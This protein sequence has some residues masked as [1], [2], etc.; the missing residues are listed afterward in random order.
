MV[1][2]VFNLFDRSKK[3][4]YLRQCQQ[5][6]RRL[7]VRHMLRDGVGNCSLRAQTRWLLLLLIVSLSTMLLFLW[8]SARHYILTGLKVQLAGEL[9]M[10]S[11]RIGKAMPNAIQGSPAAFDQLTQSRQ[12]FSQGIDI[13]MHGG[14][15]QGYLLQAPE[16]GSQVLLGEVAKVWSRTDQVE[17]A[18][19][20][21]QPELTGFGV[22]L[23]RLCQL[24]R[25][26]QDL[27][28]QILA[29]QSRRGFVWQKMAAVK[30]VRLTLHLGHCT[31]ALP[32]M[33]SIDPEVAPVLG[34]DV[35]DLREAIA[36]YLDSHRG[37]SVRGRRVKY[38]Q[39]IHEKLGELE[40]IF[41]DYEPLA[42]GILGNFQNFV[43]VKQA[44]QL[45]IA[46]NEL[47]LQQLGVLQH[48]Y[49]VIQA[50]R[51]WSFWLA[52]VSMAV[53]LLSAFG[54][55]W[56]QMDA[57]RRRAAEAEAR[58]QDA[59]AQRL[60]AQQ[61]ELR[62]IR[63]NAD[64]QEAILRLMEELQKVAD[65][66]LTVHTP[67]TD[68]IAGA[69]A[70]SVNY[71][72]AALRG[73]VSQ[74][75]HIAAQV[76]AASSQV[77]Q[78][79]EE[80]IQA[81]QVQA[82]R[83]HDTGQSMLKMSLHSTDVSISANKSADVARHSVVVAE[84]GARA[85]EDA[86]KGMNEIREQIQETSKRIKRLGVSSQEIGE[87]TE[88]ISD[89]T[90]QTNVLAL[91]A[92]IQAASAGEAGRGFSVVAEEVQRLA[93]RSSAAT[94]QIGALVRMIQDDT[95][96]A[97]AAMEKSTAGVVEGARLSDAAGVSLADIRRVSNQLAELIQ[98]ISSSAGHQATLANS[99][100]QDI[101]NIL[102][103]SEIIEARREQA[104]TLFTEL[105]ELA[106][107]LKNSASC[108]RVTLGDTPSA[109]AS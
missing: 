14:I 97:A 89:I 23:V 56:L 72:V 85:V 5:F 24:V 28:E 106:E 47:L 8:L 88:L 62:A 11:Q 20:Q 44:A 83:I 63:T 50:V 10:L 51:S 69:I 13:L 95:H 16:S 99:V 53:A 91:N 29:L 70:A 61:Q 2:I 59:E 78:D 18:I 93:E 12:Q 48:D 67:V 41:G 54:I 98:H 7:D 86:V 77:K 81:G 73:L 3:H 60:Q 108:F 30:L 43:A 101:Q 17:S 45:V 76:A 31:N 102:N 87:I 36:S 46:E 94:R 49:R 74:V 80:R 92:A 26:M 21:L 79:A 4:R 75:T 109:Q 19:L 22:A 55:V 38:Q 107:L 15:Y 100:A 103:E 34:K 32:E 39:Q 35:T 82:R 104:L 58:C 64:N 37:S 42:T 90:E 65:G 71:T 68:D 25:P 33:V 1:N 84:R 6:L 96:D 57:S 52:L 9:V 66:D 105:S 40:R 27:S